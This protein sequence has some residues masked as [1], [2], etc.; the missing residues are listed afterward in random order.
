MHFLAFQVPK[1]VEKFETMGKKG[2]MILLDGI[3]SGS[4]K[5]I[6][7]LPYSEYKE[8]KVVEVDITVLANLLI[9]PIDVNILVGDTTTFKVLQ[10]KQGKLHEIT[11]GAQYYL[12]I[13]EKKYAK[14]DGGLATGLALGTTEVILRD[15]NVIENTVKT[16]MP[17]ARLTVSEVEKITLNL[18]PHYNWVTVEQEKHEIAIDLYTKN[19]ERITLGS[20]YKM[21]SSSDVSLF[22][23]ITRTVNGSRIFGEAVKAGTNQVTGSFSNVRFIALFI[24]LSS[25][26]FVL[27]LARGQC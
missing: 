7:K 12:E 21:E 2:H 27:F 25:S 5:V 11:L 18:L 15:R 13:A 17:K 20:K 6:V 9:D 24:A 4:A 8:V 3:N 22:S 14:L 26:R 16:P 1:D 10:L 23:E 19:D